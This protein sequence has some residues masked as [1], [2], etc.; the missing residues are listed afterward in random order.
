M[1]KRSRSIFV[2]MQC[3]QKKNFISLQCFR[4]VVSLQGDMKNKYLP[5]NAS[6]FARVSLTCTLMCCLFSFSSP[7]LAD[8][9]K[10][11]LENAAF[12]SLLNKYY[13]SIH[14]AARRLSAAALFAESIPYYERILDGIEKGEYPAALKKEDRGRI[15]A[16]IYYQL[17]EACFNDGDYHKA[18]A[19]LQP[20]VVEWKQLPQ[21]EMNEDIRKS[22]YLIALACR[23]KGDF[24]AASQ[25]FQDY[26]SSGEEEQLQYYEEAQWE[27]GVALYV[28]GN[29]EEA[30]EYWRALTESSSK[31][32][33]VKLARVYLAKQALSEQNYQEVEKWLSPLVETLLPDDPLRYEISYLRAEAS[34]YLQNYAE[35]AKKFEDAL[36]R[37]NKKLADWYS[38]AL[39]NLGW[40]YLK[41]AEDPLKSQI[42]QEQFFSKAEETFME[43][44]SSIR[45]PASPLHEPLFFKEPVPSANPSPK[46][47]LEEKAILALGRLH[48]LRYFYLNDNRARSQA[49]ALFSHAETFS[50]LENRAEALLICAE[51]A[52]SYEQKAKL[53]QAL[54]DPK[55]YE[56]TRSYRHGWYDRAI[57]EYQHAGHLREMND[58][59][60][61]ALFTRSAEAFQ[62][63]YELLRDSD[64]KAAGLSLKYQSQAYFYIGTQEA[65]ALSLSL[66]NQLINEKEIYQ[67]LEEKDEVL[68]CLGLIASQLFQFNE[69]E[70]FEEIAENSLNQLVSL[71][72]DS[73][74][75]DDALFTLGN[76][77]FQNQRYESAQPVFL[78]LAKEYPSSIYAS[79]AWF[80]AAD[81]AEETETDEED[82]RFF[83]R[84]VFELYPYS[85][86]AAEAYFRS[87]SFVEYL[88]GSS[89]AFE[90]LQA[91]EALFPESPFIIVA[92]YLMGLDQKEDRKTPQGHLLHSKSLASA[93]KSLEEAQNTFDL[94]FNKKMIPEEHLD[95]LITIRYRSALEHSLI[96]LSLAEESDAPEKEKYLDTAVGDLEKIIKDFSE[97]EHAL[98]ARLL[99]ADAY[100][101]I[102]EESQFA[103]SQV[104]LKKQ[105]DE[106]AEMILSEMLNQYRSLEIASGYYLSRTWYELALLTMKKGKFEAALHRLDQAE[107]AGKNAILTVDQKLDLWIQKSHCYKSLKQTNM[108][109]LMLSHV[110]NENATSSLRI[111]AMLLRA[112]LY[113]LQGRHELAI[114]QLE[115]ASRKGGEWAQEAKEKLRKEYGLD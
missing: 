14:S 70:K 56:G 10:G 27:L 69:E 108:A 24:E 61:D 28:L 18:T 54:T 73:T 95:Y 30:Q 99:E 31:P 68:Y 44:L 40:C 52:T 94:F 113:A 7:A 43:L 103:L 60:A 39:Y 6:S 71:F 114:K 110:I 112:D 91:M 109:M 12:E 83:R 37:H 45:K 15:I 29:T 8:K 20:K 49:E 79:E 74:F 102:Y 17:A 51:A 16:A 13:Q 105:Q 50:S 115:A 32:H 66:L 65:L 55:T 82:T 46:E 104:Y 80:W 96:S 98:A 58:P 72:P 2:A 42:S 89:E 25:S 35:A 23:A 21:E 53:Y 26:L 47:P 3:S 76:L 78:E 97:P 4:A 5:L 38:R 64:K 92:K 22:L 63:S 87:Y 41:I 11:S 36:P 107:L 1:L 84:Q 19:V 86:H 33:I 67:A 57:H 93:L 62:K 77:H 100:P 88:H 101:R 111:K 34:F 85:K 81:C 9:P 75:A 106:N 48:F 90:H 59:A